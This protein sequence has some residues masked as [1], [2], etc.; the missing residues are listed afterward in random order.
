MKI[1][2]RRLAQE[3]GSVTIF[4]TAA[5]VAM[6]SMVALA[7][8]VGRMMVAKNELQ[9]AADMAALE[10]A[11]GFGNYFAPN[12]TQAA[13]KASTAVT[14]LNKVDKLALQTSDASIITGRWTE[15]AGFQAI[16]PAL[17]PGEMPAIRVSLSRTSGQGTGAIATFFARIFGVSS[18]N[19]GATAVGVLS[20]TSIEGSAA[21]PIA[22]DYC[23]AQ[24]NW[25]FSS[26]APLSGSTITIKSAYADVQESTDPTA[27]CKSGQWTSLY[28]TVNDANAVKRIMTNGSTEDLDVSK[29][30]HIEPGLKA[31]VYDDI[32]TVLKSGPVAGY[33]PVV[34]D[35]LAAFGTNP[36]D[37]VNN[38]VDLAQKSDH[39]TV[40]FVP[41]QITGVDKKNNTVSGRFLTMTEAETLIN[42]ESIRDALTNAPRLVQ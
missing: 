1:T 20:G 2:D 36:N 18:F 23:Y 12:A 42:E 4:A 19:A 6:I 13:S 28:S 24:N 15:G 41:F 31:S 27:L 39:P 11:K 30:I 26:S 9:N 8:D 7:V 14:T 17:N 35:S 37:A 33:L 25:N 3:K 32:A 16:T 21:L 40:A 29:D 5:L 34:V 38:K 10:G 22:I